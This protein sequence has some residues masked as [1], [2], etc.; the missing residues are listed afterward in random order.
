MRTLEFAD[1]TLYTAHELTQMVP[2]AGLD[3]YDQIRTRNAWVGGI[4]PN[5]N[6]APPTSFVPT[7]SISRTL[8]RPAWEA[9]LGA[10]P[11]STVERWEMNRKIR[12]LRR[13]QAAS[14][15]SDFSA[16]WCKGHAHRHQARAQ[17]A[18]DER[19]GRLQR[20]LSP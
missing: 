5:A 16:D 8:G 18:L 20:K 2:L 6:S 3:V 9:L 4:L 13:E 11:F 7:R 19:L 1:R 12:R 10:K 14:P 15:E 17:A